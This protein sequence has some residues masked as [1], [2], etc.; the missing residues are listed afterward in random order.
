M[1]YVTVTQTAFFTTFVTTGS[2][3]ALLLFQS[4]TVYWKRLLLIGVFG[5]FIWSLAFFISY[6]IVPLSA[7][8]TLGAEILRL[9]L[10]LASL[11]ALLARR[12]RIIEWPL[13][14]KIITSLTIVTAASSAICLLIGVGSASTINL[15]IMLLATFALVFTEQVVRNLNTHRM[16]KL[17]GLCLTFL[18]A[19]D[20]LMYGHNLITNDIPLTMWQTR[21]ALALTVAAA[22]GVGSMVFNENDDSHY[23]FT[24]SRPAAFY[25]TTI[26]FSAC[27]ISLVSLG[28]YYVKKQGF[29]GTY[30][31]SLA[32][33]AILLLLFSLAISREF[34]QR[35]EV[36]LS[37]HFFSLKYDYR[38]EWLHAIKLLSDL[39]SASSSYYKNILTMLCE[40]VRAEAGSLW[41]NDNSTFK[42]IVS[43]IKLEGAP[44]SI[45]VNEPFIR[46]MLKES[47]IFVPGS[48]ATSLAQNNRLLP[49]W[50]EKNE[51]IWLVAPLI[52]QMKLV[53]FVILARPKLGSDITF[54]DRDLMT[55]VSTQVASNILLHQQERVI[56]D[57]KQLE[58]YNRL[59]AFI[60]HDINNV[61]A[62]LALIG[63]NAERH[64][65]NPAFIEDMIKTVHNATS[66][67]QGLIQKFNPA[68]KEQK[69][70]FLASELLLELVQECSC[71]KPMP[72]LMVN[73]DFE[74]KADKQRLSL[75]L[76]NLIR[77]AQEATAASGQVNVISETQNGVSRIIIEDT[78]QGMSEYFIREELFRPFATTKQENGVGI[79][80]YLTKSYIEHL[81][82]NLNV[83]SE[84]DK[85]SRFEIAFS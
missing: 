3:L 17:I 27:L 19:F 34:R 62:Q 10:W 28:S 50:I 77:N 63:K 4:I 25:S 54:E 83:Q 68:T 53:G 8:M 51:S 69:T 45:N 75:A 26:L 85:G 13:K 20:V 70:S 24:V 35:C 47:W 18:F 6:S 30:L 22:L 16:I 60:M 44:E 49:D 72:R 37:K 36:F 76:K 67:M 42:Q 7:K 40:V 29:L 11:F 38:T 79:G 32:M 80:A 57:T 39:D 41:I 58:T 65:N 23:L 78:G 33:T 12:V 52:I 43:N 66:R 5:Q 73:N 46:T 15:L 1:D 82:A 21:A 81:G 74:L 31:F 61:I 56:S 84:P 48:R 9:F 55:N 59:S 2:L 14:L 71:Y 64:K